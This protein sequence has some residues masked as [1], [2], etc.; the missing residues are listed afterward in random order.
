MLRHGVSEKPEPKP[1]LF[2]RPQPPACCAGKAARRTKL[3]LL[4]ILAV[5]ALA[6]LLARSLPVSHAPP[7]RSGR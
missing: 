2:M 3:V 6:P 5:L 4:L 1:R 7:V